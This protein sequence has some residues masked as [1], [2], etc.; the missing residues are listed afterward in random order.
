MTNL[1]T[2]L[3]SPLMAASGAE[4]PMQLRGKSVRSC[5]SAVI[6]GSGENRLARRSV[7]WR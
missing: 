2:A 3:G 1:V 5:P 6:Q 7:E 4:L